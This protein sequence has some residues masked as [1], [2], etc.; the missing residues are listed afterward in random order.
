MTIRENRHREESPLAKQSSISNYM[1][2][3]DD[4]FREFNGDV[5]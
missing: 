3:F 1:D 4:V 5:D 2:V